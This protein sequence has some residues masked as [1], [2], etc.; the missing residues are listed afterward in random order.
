MPVP[1]PL[2]ESDSSSSDDDDEEFHNLDSADSNSESSSKYTDSPE[3]NQKLQ[4]TV[5][6]FVHY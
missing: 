1:S 5:R 3:F 4:C 2:K 6:Y